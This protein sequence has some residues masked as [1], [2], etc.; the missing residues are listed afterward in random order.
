[1]SSSWGR[2]SSLVQR[3]WLS[4]NATCRADVS[5]LLPTK[6]RH[7]LTSHSSAQVSESSRSG[8]SSPRAQAN[9]APTIPPPMIATSTTFCCSARQKGRACL[10]EARRLV[11]LS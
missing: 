1:M 8:L 6:Y 2:Y 4:I 5:G 9:E 11:M 7:R 3:T 10:M